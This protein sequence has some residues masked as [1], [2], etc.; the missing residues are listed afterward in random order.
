MPTTGTVCQLELI[1]EHPREHWDKEKRFF[2]TDL[3]TSPPIIQF[4]LIFRCTK[5]GTNLGW[6]CVYFGI[7]CLGNEESRW[8]HIK[9]YQSGDLTPLDIDSPVS[10]GEKCQSH[11]TRGGEVSLKC[12]MSLVAVSGQKVYAVDLHAR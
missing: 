5:H 6:F 12:H 1:K 4:A 2:R 9:F 3:T 8:C 7:D 10:E 11:V